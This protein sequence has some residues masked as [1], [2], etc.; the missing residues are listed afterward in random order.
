MHLIT[1]FSAAL[2]LFTASCSTPKN[3]ITY[4][5]PDVEIPDEGLSTKIVVLNFNIIKSKNNQLDI[6]L[7]NREL[8]PG[9]LNESEMIYPPKELGK[10]VIHLL[11]SNS[12]I[13]EELVIKKSY[14]QIIEKYNS[15]ENIEL[16][17]DSIEEIP[18]TVRFNE[19]NSV[20]SIKIFKLEGEGIF[21]IF[22]ENLIQK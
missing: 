12:Q 21:E 13:I 18:L 22:H 20:K 16:Q 5:V 11:D 2:L 15:E 8:I 1:L 10:L 17:N 7:T 9:R 3:V 19:N 6:S 14:L 4:S